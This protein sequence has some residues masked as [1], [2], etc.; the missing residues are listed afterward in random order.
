MRSSSHVRFAA[1][2]SAIIGRVYRRKRVGG[3]LS[4]Y[5][6]SAAVRSSAGQNALEIDRGRALLPEMAGAAAARMVTLPGGS[7]FRSLLTEPT[8]IPL[9]SILPSA[10][11]GVGTFTP[12]PARCCNR[13]MRGMEAHRGRERRGCAHSDTK[14]A[15]HHGTLVPSKV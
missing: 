9:K 15:A 10:V 6:R 2:M 4:Y 14:R 1:A 12:A 3:I 11:N 7:G 13:R 5:Y 8:H